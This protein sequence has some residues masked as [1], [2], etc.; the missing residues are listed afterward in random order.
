MTKFLICKGKDR[1]FFLSSANTT[2]HY[3]CHGFDRDPT[4]PFKAVREAWDP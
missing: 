4:R 2:A 1:P 3:T